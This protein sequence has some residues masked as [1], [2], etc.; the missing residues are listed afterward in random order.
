MIKKKDGVVRYL[1]II[2]VVVVVVRIIFARQRGENGQ[3]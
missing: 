1:I 2:I 3:P